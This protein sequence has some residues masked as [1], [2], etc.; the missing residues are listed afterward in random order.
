MQHTGSIV[1]HLL[2]LKPEAA[3]PHYLSLQAEFSVYR[4]GEFVQVSEDP[5]RDIL[6]EIMVHIQSVDVGQSPYGLPGHLVQV[7]VTEVEVFQC[8]QE[9]IKG[10]WGYGVELVVR[11]DQV[12]QVSQA[13]EMVVLVDKRE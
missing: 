12:P 4:P 9:V 5:L 7:V 3:L 6:D 13:F 2:A 8:G 1:I 11:Q 10:M